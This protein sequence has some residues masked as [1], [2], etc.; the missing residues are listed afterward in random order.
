MRR[1]F[2]VDVLA[3]PH[4]LGRLRFVA[5]IEASAAVRQILTHRA[6]PADVPR[7]APA[8]APPISDDDA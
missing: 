3:C 4:G 2:A 8:R 5:L 7:P 6:L 1:A